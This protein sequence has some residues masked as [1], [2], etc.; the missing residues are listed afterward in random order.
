MPQCKYSSSVVEVTPNY[1]CVRAIRPW[2]LELVHKSQV[3]G[4]ASPGDSVTVTVTD[5]EY[6]VL[7]DQKCTAPQIRKAG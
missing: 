1:V 5:G 4:E 2:E 6:V 7:C 3:R